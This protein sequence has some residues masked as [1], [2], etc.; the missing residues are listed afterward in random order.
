MERKQ[1]SLGT[2]SSQATGAC[3]D[4]VFRF[5]SLPEEVSHHILSFLPV[6]D[7]VR[8]GGL[9][10]KCQEFQLSTPSVNFVGFSS[11]PNNRHFRLLGCLDRFLF[12]RGDNKI[13][14][15]RVDWNLVLGKTASIYN[16]L[17]R[18]MTWVH[19]AVKCN[20][21]ELDLK[22]RILEATTFELPICVFDCK[23]LS[24]LLVECGTALATPS[25]ACSTNLQYIKLRKVKID[26]GFCKWISFSCKCIKE[27]QFEEVKV[28][29]ITIDSSSLESFS[30]VSPSFCGVR[31]LLI[32]GKKLE[33]ID[34]E[35]RCALPS[36]TS[37]DVSAPN[38]R[39]FKWTGNLL[40]HQNMGNLMCLEKAE[41]FLSP[42]ADYNF[43]NAFGVLH[44]LCKVKVL[45][46]SEET[47]KALFR[48]GHIPAQFD[49]ISYLAMDIT[50]WDDDVVSAMVSLMK[51][52][53]NLNTLN[54]KSNHS[55]NVTKPE[56]CRFDR[57][58]WKSQNLT[59]I[60]ELKEVTIEFFCGNIELEL[61]NYIL[62]DA[63]NLQKMVIIYSPQQSNLIRGLKKSK[64][65]STAIIVC[66][67]K[68]R[69]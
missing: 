44:S 46:L 43:D 1:K 10:K 20:V 9:S 28:E 11:L 2:S 13:R 66:Q 53:P 69:K 65:N 55:I 16:E 49:D 19:A 62:E 50:S 26:E 7:L 67:E 56:E 3:V 12:L 57:T 61:A 63:K 42:S 31:Q 6:K 48:E 41:I 14:R 47:V 17:Y 35:W 39:S 58:Y 29:N 52:M 4:S 36:G 8:Y 23:S 64:M 30:L 51:G 38:L 15:F 45:I 21:E 27:L 24:S 25:V 5:F 32:S 60:L 18:V 68:Q 40:K 54:L 37:L 34:I 33:K 22:L 59:F